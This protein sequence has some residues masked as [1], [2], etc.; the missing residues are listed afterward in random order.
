MN[1]ILYVDKNKKGGTLEVKTIIK[2]FAF[3]I[4]A[5]GIILIAKGTYGIFKSDNNS[6]EQPIVSIEQ[7]DNKLKINIIHNKAI[8]KIIYSWNNEKEVTL[9]AKGQNQITETIEMP[10]GTNILNLKIIDNNNKTVNY[11]KEY[12]LEDKDTISPQIEFVVEGSKVKIVVK[13]ETELSYIMYHWNDED[14]TIIEVREDSKK[15]IEEKISILKGENTLTIVAVDATGNEVT[16]QQVFKGA[17][18]PTV[19]INQENDELIIQVKDEENIQKIEITLN[20][21]FYSTDPENAGVAL[22]MKEV[23]LRQKLQSGTNTIT[24]T[25]YNVSGLSEQVTKEVT[26]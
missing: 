10:I 20:G 5:F 22:N 25:A 12:T 18:K 8:N 9:Q 14:N 3:I 17:K 15:L 13:D 6:S 4:I 7:V 11:K 1:Q 24:I 23:E 2:I 16:K 19:Q 21:A 26:L